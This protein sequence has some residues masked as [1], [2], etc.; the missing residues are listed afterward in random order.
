MLLYSPHFLGP[1][2]LLKIVIAIPVNLIWRIRVDM[3]QK[4]A[5][6]LSL[7]LSVVMIIVTIIRASGLLT[8]SGNSVDVLWE[9]YWQ[10][11]EASVAIIM[12]SLTAFRSFFVVRS[13]R[14][15]QAHRATSYSTHLALVKR[16]FTPRTWRKSSAEQQGFELSD[17]KLHELPKQPLPDIPRPVM[18]GMHTFIQGREGS[19]SANPLSMQSYTQPLEEDDNDPLWT[20]N[21]GT[22]HKAITIQ[23]DLSLRSERVCGS[24]IESA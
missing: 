15:Q 20:S 14:V 13:S 2:E 16:I 9:V 6:A 19:N 24:N 10:Y 22:H 7:C 8:K 21:G 18:T 5:L 11:V 4:L 3:T 1:A 17:G 12:A 23:H